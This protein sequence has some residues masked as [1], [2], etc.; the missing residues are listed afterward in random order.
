MIINL[1][2]KSLKGWNQEFSATDEVIKSFVCK[3]TSTKDKETKNERASVGDWPERDP[4][5]K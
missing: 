3:R 5:V 4:S 1:K 2:I